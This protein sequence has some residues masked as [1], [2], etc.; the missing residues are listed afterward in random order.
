[1]SIVNFISSWLK[2]IVVLFILISIAELVMP[3]GNMKR[4]IDLIIGFLIIFTIITPFA[5][6]I[7]KDFSFDETVFNYSNSSNF[8]ERDDERFQIEQEKQIE[9]LYK[10][11][12]KN[13]IIKLVEE[14]SLYTVHDVLVG[15]ME[16]EDLYGEILYLE[17]ILIEKD[18]VIKENK[19]AIEKVEIV[20]I[21]KEL[22]SNIQEDQNDYIQLNKLIASKYDVD[23]DKISIIKY[24]ERNGD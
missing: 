19:V 10:E 23:K 7:K 12:I 16:E 4:Y 21:N 1:M 2:D 14:E 20:D 18:E 11:K 13:E 9:R 15:L 17:I 8:I 24:E 5:K 3:K 6:I 22:P